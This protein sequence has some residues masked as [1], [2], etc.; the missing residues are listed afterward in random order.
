MR[1]QYGLE[2]F[3]QRFATKVLWHFTGYKKSEEK[4]FLILKQM[5][6]EKILKVGGSN[7]AGR[8]SFHL[9]FLKGKGKKVLHIRFFTSSH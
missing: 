1:P 6:K 4:A 9:L 8:T 2:D 5:L 3:L 7:P